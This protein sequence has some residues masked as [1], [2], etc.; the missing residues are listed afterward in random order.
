M[1]ELYQI[2]KKI[3]DKID[4]LDIKESEKDFLKEALLLQYKNRDVENEDLKKDYEKLV[5][6]HYSQVIL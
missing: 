1:S 5:D 4:S 6:N 2:N 3:I